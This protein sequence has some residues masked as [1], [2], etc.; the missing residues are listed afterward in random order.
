MEIWGSERDLPEAIEEALDDGHF[1]GTFVND[2]RGVS[3]MLLRPFLKVLPVS[4]VMTL[5]RDFC[6]SSSFISRLE[7]KF[8]LDRIL[9][10]LKE[11]GA[12]LRPDVVDAIKLGLEDAAQRGRTLESGVVA[13]KLTETLD[14]LAARQ[15]LAA[16]RRCPHRLIAR[17]CSSMPCRSPSLCMGTF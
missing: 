12:K 16:V 11:C 6:T 15:S 8:S 3:L 1:R 2:R 4:E 14:E 13:T 5:A 10:R 9:A 7:N 17:F